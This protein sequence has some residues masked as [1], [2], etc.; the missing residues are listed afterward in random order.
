M[1]VEPN[2]EVCRTI[3]VQ[4]GLP[5]QFVVKEFHV[6]EV[7]GQI[8]ASTASLKN[9]VFKG[10]T[11]L[12][13]VYLGKT[14]R[15]SEDLDFDLEAE[16]LAR[17]RDRCGRIAEKIS[18][19]ETTDFRRVGGTI[20]FYC[21]FDSPLKVKDHVRVDIAAKKILTSRPLEIKPAV[22]DYTQRSVMGF[23][24]YA[25][26][27][28]VARKIHAL[29]TRAEGK[30]VFDV[31]NT[32]PLC[33]EMGGAMKTML[34]SEQSRETPVEFIEKT[35]NALKKADARKLRD[36]TNQFI[37]FAERPKDWQELKNDL[38]L[39]LGAIHIS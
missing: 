32:L 3:A 11:A 7:L 36:H 28:L 14:Q 17:V 2:L 38:A 1:A 5:L 34:E 37:P 15:F 4:Y 10:G 27:D 6:F 22:S 31:Y 26:E 23:K 8:T 12:N 9:F 30:D 29:R 19:Y 25:L 13:K 20:Q 16:S 24:V 18:G 39:K 33:A 35:I 21:V